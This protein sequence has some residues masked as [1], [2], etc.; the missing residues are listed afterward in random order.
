MGKS[1]NFL[2]PFSLIWGEAFAT[3]FLPTFLKIFAKVPP[4]LLFSSIY[5]KSLELTFQGLPR[6]GLNH[7]LIQVPGPFHLHASARLAAGWENQSPSVFLIP[8]P[9][10]LHPQG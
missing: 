4:P 7:H 5:L 2:K 1:L 6:P 3:N 10:P 9:P 8:A